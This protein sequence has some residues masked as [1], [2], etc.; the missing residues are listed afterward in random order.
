MAKQPGHLWALIQA[1]LDADWN[2][3]SQNRLATRFGVSASSLGDYKYAEHMPG[4]AFVEKVAA[5]IQVP[6]ETVLDAVL[7][8]AGY[9]PA[10]LTMGRK[11]S[12][13]LGSLA[14]KRTAKHPASDEDLEIAEHEG[15]AAARRAQSGGR[16][17]RARQDQEATA[18]D[19]PGEDAGA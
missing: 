12:G 15:A 6:Y 11:G 1:W 3:P 19:E 16:N 17:A 10:T 13:K 9:R 2:P 14:A 18:P 5:E 7:R 8:D 4:P